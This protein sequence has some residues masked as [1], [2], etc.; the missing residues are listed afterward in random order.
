MN[1]IIF[2]G[3]QLILGL[4]EVMRSSTGNRPLTFTCVYEVADYTLMFKL[5]FD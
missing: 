2:L 3:T 1:T 4:G 5:S